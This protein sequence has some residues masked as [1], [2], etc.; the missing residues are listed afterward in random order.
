MRVE[1]FVG[2]LLFCFF[3]KYYVIGVIYVMIFFGLVVCYYNLYF[4]LFL[5]VE[6]YLVVIVICRVCV[7]WF[8]ES[9]ICWFMILLLRF[10]VF[11]LLISFF[12]FWFI[13]F[14]FVF[15]MRCWEFDLFIIFLGFNFILFWGFFLFLFVS[16]KVWIIVKWSWEYSNFVLCW[17]CLLFLV[18]LFDSGIR[19][20]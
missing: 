2:L 20:I 7:N 14:K 13:F 1:V 17:V 19:I 5:V 10:N 16:K 8:R 6:R 4:F 3:I 12:I 15:L 18:K 9:W 11:N